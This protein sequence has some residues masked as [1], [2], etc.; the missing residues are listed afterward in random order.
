M[1]DIKKHIF[2][3]SQ[4]STAI[5]LKQCRYRRMYKSCGVCDQYCNQAK[6]EETKRK[7]TGKRTIRTRTK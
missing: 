2:K 4:F 1:A 5:N 7:T 3:C 6:K